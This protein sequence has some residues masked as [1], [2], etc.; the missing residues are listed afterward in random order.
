MVHDLIFS[1]HVHTEGGVVLANS[2][3]MAQLQEQAQLMQAHRRNNPPK[4]LPPA[5]VQKYTVEYRVFDPQ[6]KAQAA[7]TGRQPTLEF[8]IA[9]FDSDGKMINGMVNDAVLESSTSPDQN[10]SGLFRA[11]QSLV[12]PMNAVSMRVGVRDRISDRMGTLEVPLPLKPEP[13]AQ[14]TNPH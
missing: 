1:A 7:R 8:A 9:A 2:E 5:K 10:K 14:M 11:H 6:F 4:P 12:V 3:E 13:V